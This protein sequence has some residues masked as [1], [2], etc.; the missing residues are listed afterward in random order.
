M[1]KYF[2]CFCQPFRIISKIALSL[3][4]GAHLFLTVFPHLLHLKTITFP[5]FGLSSIWMGIKSPLQLFCLSPGFISTC[6]EH[7]QYGQWLREETLSGSTIFLQFWQTKPLS[8]LVNTFIFAPFFWTK[9]ITFVLEFVFL[10]LFFL[11]NFQANFVT[12]FVL[13]AY[14]LL[15]KTS[16]FFIQNLRISNTT[17]IILGWYKICIVQVKA[18]WFVFCSLN[19]KKTC[20]CHL[21]TIM[22]EFLVKWRKTTFFTA[23]FFLKQSYPW[24]VILCI[25]VAKVNGLAD[26][27][28]IM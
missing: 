18:N 1:S 5:F 19:I 26:G 4:S 13:S 10:C 9:V 8:F 22:H 14:K 17:V 2:W 15:W 21:E 16:A 24:V 23:N 7:K 25:A 27:K 3:S 28:L 12:D 11:C 6:N 20:C